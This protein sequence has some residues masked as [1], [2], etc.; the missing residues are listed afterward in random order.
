MGDD[1][2]RVRDDFYILSS[3]A[4]IDDRTR[5][6]K[7]GDT[8]AVFD[9]FGDVE[10]VG[11]GEHGIY[12]LDTRFLSRFVLRL[13]EKRPLLLSSM[14][15]ADNAVLLVDLM[16]PDVGGNGAVRIHRGEVHLSRAKVLWDTTCHERLRI[17]NYGGSTAELAL[18]I[19]FDADF[20]DIFEVRGLER[21]ECGRRLAP[22]VTHDGVLLSYEGLDRKI[23]STRIAFDPPP[24]QLSES[25]ARYAIRL[26]PQSGRKYRIAISCSVENA[27]ETTAVP[28]AASTFVVDPGSAWYEEASEG[29][30]AAFAEARAGKPEI[31]TSNEQFNDWL[32]RSI[33]DLQM[34]R[35]ETIHGPY[36]YAGVPWFS[37][38]FGRDGII[39]A[40]ECL[41]FDPS[42]AR[43]VL[44]Y[45]AATQADTENAVQDAQPGKILHETRSGEMAVLGEVPFGQYY[46]STDATPLFVML[47]RAYHER[48][49]EL[50]FA[51]SIWPHVERAL[52]WLDQFGDA[53]GDGFIEY[54]RE[55]PHGL[56][57]QGWKDSQDSVFH[58]DGSLATPP[59]ALCEIQGY[60]YAARTAG[61]ALA[62]ALGMPE[63]AKRLMAQANMLQRRFEEAFWCEDLSTYALALDHRK[64]RCR[65]RASNAGH[66]LFSGIASRAH[67]SRVANTLTGEASFS[68]W[69]IRTIA[70]GE[71]RYNPMSYHNGSV[72]PHDTALIAAGLGRYGF[73]DDAMKLL[74]GLFDASL[75]F[76][77]HRLPELFCGFPRRA[78]DGPTLYPVSCAPQAW[79]S[80][81]A[82]MLL[83]ACLGLEVRGA[84]RK[85]VFSDPR[86]PEYLHEVHIRGLRIGEGAMDL[87]LVRH[88]DDV[89]VHILRR[90]GDVGMI[91]MK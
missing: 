14:V 75:H 2:V 22:Q 70:V 38:P 26:A 84:D 39:S 69:G 45:L 32:N 68:G 7:H 80:A 81:A 25:E 79:A 28:R 61:A 71:A 33:A 82:L 88:A 15:T 24:S 66:C 72:W 23:R 17:H 35:T 56:L 5:V 3:S 8:F 41:W 49:G 65:V 10:Q 18:C 36:P 19:D 58:Q 11:T 50:D 89:G 73:R 47:A 78:G 52:D 63:R 64:H 74:T 87:V 31:F 21:K 29:A 16:N 27:E 20:A 37:T 55:S 86:L 6:L 40:L 9:R 12:H 62:S 1:V 57:H 51:R 4:R 42:V 44:Q 59:I 76:D 13:E 30:A 91:V 90:E 83:Q 67:A 34:L 46:G 85:L 43:G 60:A 48:S 53:D 77:L 54:A